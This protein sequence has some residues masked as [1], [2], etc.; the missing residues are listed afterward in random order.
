MCVFLHGVQVFDRFYVLRDNAAHKRGKRRQNAGLPA[1]VCLLN[2]GFVS[3]FAFAV[4]NVERGTKSTETTFCRLLTS[5][6]GNLCLAQITINS[7]VKSR[8]GNASTLGQRK[9]GGNPRLQGAESITPASPKSAA[10]CR[11]AGP[12]E[13]RSDFFRQFFFLQFSTFMI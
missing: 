5:D 7:E 8:R 1:F 3:R 9:I 2:V 11:R 10:E 12:D 6:W 4:A 13:P